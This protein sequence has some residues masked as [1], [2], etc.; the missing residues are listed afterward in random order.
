M[1]NYLNNRKCLYFS[2]ILIKLLDI[3][4]DTKNLIKTK[5]L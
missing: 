5:R 2:Q 3:V 4:L 1:I